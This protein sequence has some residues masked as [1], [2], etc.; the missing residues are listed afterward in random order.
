MKGLGS[1]KKYIM[2]SSDNPKLSLLLLI[3]GYLFLTA[4][5]LLILML[6]FSRNVDIAFVDQLFLATSIVSTTGLSPI[7]FGA[8]FNL[9]GELSS[10]F[11][12]Q[13]GGIGY[14]A[15]SS[16]IILKDSPKLPK[17]SISLLR[18][19]YNLPERYPLLSFI[20]SVLIFTI[21]IEV[22]G[23]IFLYIGFKDAGVDQPIWS[24]IFHSVS[25]FC[26]AGFSLFSDSMSSF[27]DNLLITN[28]IL[29]LS[30]LGSVGFIVLLDF[31]L[32]IIRQ[33][34]HV[35]LTSKLILVSTVVY[36]VVGTL[37]L[38][39]SDGLLIAD[40]FKGLKIAFFQLISA[41]T[42]VGF[43]NFPIENLKLG[44]LLIMIVF[45]IIGAS[46]AGTGGG[47]KTTS[48]TALIGLL[49]SILRK[50]KHITFF[51][52][53]IPTQK[54]YLA[55]SSSIFYTA[56]LLLGTWV[57]VQIDGDEMSFGKLLFECASALSTVGL[58]T[59]I[60][61]DLS[62][63]NKLTIC[64]LMFI[65]RLGVMTFGFALISQSP[66]SRAKPK[67]EDIAL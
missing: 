17:I 24:A 58:S 45:M 10:L 40:G 43:N 1:I 39:I 2:K 19:E 64:V 35:T 63:A 29:V 67:I 15:L 3:Q 16:L 37:L 55:I 52:R 36:I 41:H 53:E 18:L 30:I 14:M 20:Y 54:I 48:V 4:L 34:K 7:D 61:A 8:S 49:Y 28:T 47:I 31:W 65:G 12:I 27:Q 46:P 59:G 51:K 62:A 42:T 6:P 5:C 33:R 32:K 21:F 9:F 22:I 11:F 38:Y 25:A 66:L 60:T 23:A 26:T 56:I 57:V 50:R 44:G 13:L